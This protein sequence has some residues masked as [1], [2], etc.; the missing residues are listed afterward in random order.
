M[1]V[2]ILLCFFSHTGMY[3]CRGERERES[4]L[5]L[6]LLLQPNDD[7]DDGCAARH[8]MAFAAES[9]S[10]SNVHPTVGRSQTLHTI[11]HYVI[12]TSLAAPLRSKSLAL[13]HPGEQDVIG[14]CIME[15]S[16]LLLQINDRRRHGGRRTTTQHPGLSVCLS[17]AELACTV[18]S[19]LL[20]EQ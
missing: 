1:Y 6:L 3:V 12:C 9:W 13:S 20:V 2:C 18:P 14:R 5:L 4:P 10:F 8:G 19:C 7:D 11:N 15:S 17:V 16:I